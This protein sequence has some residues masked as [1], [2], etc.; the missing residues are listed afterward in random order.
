MLS[1]NLCKDP[2]LIPSS[3]HPDMPDEIYSSWTKFPSA[4]HSDM[5]S[6]LYLSLPKS[7]A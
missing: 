6:Q 1:F 3:A 5:P 2:Y 7:Y 4:A